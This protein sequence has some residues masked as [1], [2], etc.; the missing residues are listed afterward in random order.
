MKFLLSVILAAGLSI[1]MMN[2][3]I[4]EPD[5]I[6]VK[7]AGAE[8]FSIYSPGSQI[9]DNPAAQISGFGYALLT[10]LL[11][12]YALWGTSVFG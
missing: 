6:I 10:V 4:F 12:C 2:A 1:W 9:V 3:G 5:K 7:V 11:T 8:T